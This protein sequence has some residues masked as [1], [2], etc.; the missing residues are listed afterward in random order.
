MYVVP[1]D[2]SSKGCA[3]L[4]EAERLKGELP[5]QPTF[6]SLQGTLLMYERCVSRCSDSDSVAVAR[7][8]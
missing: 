5:A 4:A 1:G 6:T 7:L 8:S 2:I 3:F